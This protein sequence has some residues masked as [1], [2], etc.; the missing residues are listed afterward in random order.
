MLKIVKKILYNSALLVSP[1]DKKFLRY[2]KNKLVLFGEYTPLKYFREM[3]NT[4]N[5]DQFAHGTTK[6]IF[7]LLKKEFSS[8][9]KNDHTKH[10]YRACINIC[11]ESSLPHFIRKQ[12][13]HHKYNNN[14]PDF[15]INLADNTNF[16]NTSLIYLSV[17]TQV[18]RA[19]EN[20]KTFVCATDSGFAT[21]I[22]KQGRII[23]VRHENSTGFV[24]A[25]IVHENSYSFYTEYG[26]WF[27]ICCAIFCGVLLKRGMIPTISQK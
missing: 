19:V 13:C 16:G 5:F 10:C 4:K 21:W 23:Q 1:N 15:L 11:Y 9:S 25:N 8:E 6:I 12:I 22:D 24:I 3:F 18:F 7:P 20:R 14:E 27:S 17:A 2:D 26:D